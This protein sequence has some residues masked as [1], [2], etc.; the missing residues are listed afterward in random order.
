MW[1]DPLPVGNAGKSLGTNSH[2]CCVTE[3][4]KGVGLAS[5]A[6][7]SGAF[8]VISTGGNYYIPVT[9]ETTLMHS[10]KNSASV[11]ANPHISAHFHVSDC[12]G[13]GHPWSAILP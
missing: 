3:N 9:S 11:K 10:C 4:C 7:Q 5:L 13:S 2:A 8:E 6:K 1:S 12:K